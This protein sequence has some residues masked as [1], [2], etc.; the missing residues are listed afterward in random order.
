MTTGGDGFERFDAAVSYE[1]CDIEIVYCGT[2]VSREKIKRVPEL[3]SQCSFFYGDRQMLFTGSER[4]ESGVAEEDAGGDAGIG[5]D[6]FVPGVAGQN[7]RARMT[8]HRRNDDCGRPVPPLSRQ[9]PRPT[10]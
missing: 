8:D 3:R 6:G 9:L 2:D 7:I 1:Q 4:G 5:G 10:S